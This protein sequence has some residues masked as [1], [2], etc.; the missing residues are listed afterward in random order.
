MASISEILNRDLRTIFSLPRKAEKFDNRSDFD[1]CFNCD[2]CQNKNRTKSNLIR[3]S[4]STKS[5]F[6]KSK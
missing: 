1:V 5:L 6:T 4:K 3:L 2:K